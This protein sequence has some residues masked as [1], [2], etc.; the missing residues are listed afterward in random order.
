MSYRNIIDSFRK[1]ARDHALTIEFEDGLN[2]VLR[3]G[4]PGSMVFECRIITWKGGLTYT[5]DMGTFTFCRID[6]MLQFFRG[7]QGI[8]NDDLRIN[9]GYWS[10]KLQRPTESDEWSDHYATE[11]VKEWIADQRH[12]DIEAIG[13]EEY[14]KWLSGDLEDD[15][16][17]DTPKSINMQIYFDE[18]M[19][20]SIESPSEM[21]RFADEFNIS[22]W[23][24]ST[25]M[26]KTYHFVWCCYAL[27]RAI[28]MYD[29]LKREN[30]HLT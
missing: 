28:Q 6:D 10:E 22:D 3:F 21:E 29:Q 20:S 30:K 19:Y 27:V 23:Y 5:G 18:E 26:Q 25:H 15:D 1:D 11:S 2:R 14:E 13:K 9:T 8:A 24:E 16:E 7:T 4:R 17:H 12:E